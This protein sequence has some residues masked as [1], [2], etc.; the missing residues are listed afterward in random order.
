[1]FEASLSNGHGVGA[2]RLKA[3]QEAENPRIARLDTTWTTAVPGQ[4]DTLRLG[5][6]VNQSGI[7]GR[8][9][10]FG[11][12]HYGTDL[13]S[14]LTTDAVTQ[15]PRPALALVQPGF[16]DRA[17]AVGFLR[18]NYSLEGDR[19]GEPFASAT[20]RFG[21]SE[22]LT[23]EVRGS[24][25]SGVSNGGIAFLVRLNGLGLITAAAASSNSEAGSG[26]LAQ[27]GFE[28]QRGRLSASISSAW[29]SSEFRRL[30]LDDEDIPPRYWSVA[31]ATF[32][33]A[34]YGVFGIGYA[35]VADDEGL[36]ETLQGTYR[37]AVGPHSTLTV[38]VSQTFAPELDT[39]LMLTV[40]LPLD[41][42]VRTGGARAGVAASTTWIFERYPQPTPVAHPFSGEG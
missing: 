28:Y 31:S 18:S 15:L 16:V 38:S 12:L 25:Q 26:H 36:W 27:T 8:P 22:D 11:G 4:R 5:D 3:D 19:Y 39:S 24:A 41:R 33:T 6:S 23:T 2:I 32:D 1:V 9:V 35:A 17:Y 29:A 42:V 13:G 14:G 21:V 30:R 7:W 37:I 10:R 20:L 34:R 40:T